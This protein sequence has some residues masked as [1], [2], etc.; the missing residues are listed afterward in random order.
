[1]K[2]WIFLS[3]ITVTTAL[4]SFVQGIDKSTMERGKAVYESSCAPCHLEDGEGI[5]EMNPPLK[6]TK[7]VLGDKKILIGILLKGMEQPITINGQVYGNPMPSQAHL[8]D[9][10]IRDV[11]TYVRNSFGNKA[12]AVTLAEVKAQRKLIK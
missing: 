9:E 1:M 7:W 5:S 6:K 12:T 8:S 3:V 4:F 11:L 2:V 10:E